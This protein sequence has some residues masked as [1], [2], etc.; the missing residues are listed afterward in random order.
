[1]TEDDCVVFRISIKLIRKVWSMTFW[2]D[3]V[4]EMSVFSKYVFGDDLDDYCWIVSCYSDRGNIWK[5]KFASL[6][7]LVSS[8]STSFGQTGLIST[9]IVWTLCSL[10]LKL[11]H[12][13]A[14]R[15]M[16]KTVVNTFKNTLRC[17]IRLFTRVW[18]HVSA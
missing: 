9:A 10:V 2:C 16:L 7:T 18:N 11:F 13:S 1:L 17:R 3:H 15:P 12:S 5:G 14:S 8:F 6:L 4:L